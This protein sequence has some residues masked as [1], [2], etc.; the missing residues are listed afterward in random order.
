MEIVDTTEL[1]PLQT[2]WQ[3]E[4]YVIVLIGMIIAVGA[5]YF[6]FSV[7]VLLFTIGMYFMLVE[8]FVWLGNMLKF[9]ARLLLFC[10][11]TI[12]GIAKKERSFPYFVVSAFTLTTAYTIF[13]YGGVQQVPSTLLLS[14]IFGLLGGFLHLDQHC[15][16]RW[17]IN[18]L[19]MISCR[20]EPLE[21]DVRE[22]VW[23]LRRKFKQLK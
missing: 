18:Q 14:L 22:T 5:T 10:A 11:K 21:R 16:P 3:K 2:R 23:L 4:A 17:I 8:A 6:P 7:T 13:V 12:Y 1:F 15:R 19:V 9:L 20:L